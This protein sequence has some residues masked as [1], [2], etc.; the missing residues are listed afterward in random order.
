M[1]RFKRLIPLS[2]TVIQICLLY[3]QL[4]PNPNLSSKGLDYLMS[5]ILQ[6]LFKTKYNLSSS[7][8]LIIICKL[9]SLSLTF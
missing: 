1:K 4:A 7:N 8:K 9:V 6:L 5:T 2:L 3:C